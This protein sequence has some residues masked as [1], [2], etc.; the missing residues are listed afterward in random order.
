MNELSNATD[1]L[2]NDEFAKLFT[3]LEKGLI[4]ILNIWNLCNKKV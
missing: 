3:N 4:G 1:S 2:I